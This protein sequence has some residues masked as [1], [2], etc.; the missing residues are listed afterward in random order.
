MK[1]L[2]KEWYETMQRSSLHLLIEPLEEARSF[3][4]ELFQQLYAQKE[5]EH[6]DSEKRVYDIDIEE[7]ADKLS[8]ASVQHADGTPLTEEEYEE[9]IAVQ[10]NLTQALRESPERIFDPEIVKAKYHE[11]YLASLKNAQSKLP[12]EIKQKIA[13][14]RVFALRHATPEIIEEVAAYS[15]SCAEFVD[16]TIKEVSEREKAFFADNRPAFFEHYHIHD[17]QIKSSHFSEEDFVLEPFSKYDPI[18]TFKNAKILV[19]ERELDHSYMLYDEIYPTESGYE[20]HFLLGFY[21]NGAS[22]HFELTLRCS[23]LEITYA[24]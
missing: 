14:L 22:E 11:R 6:L 16:R 15:K 5:Q 23:D 1:Y 20:F 3:S 4:E 21:E 18:F 2:T 19:Q 8:Y 10:E 24:E 9:A 13:D 12:D 7:L 17:H